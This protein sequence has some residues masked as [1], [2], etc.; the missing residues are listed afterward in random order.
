MRTI[1]T[2][3]VPDDS[4]NPEKQQGLQ[5]MIELKFLEQPVKNMLP[6]ILVPIMLL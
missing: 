3:S 1:R 2:D 4:K 5:K 6:Y